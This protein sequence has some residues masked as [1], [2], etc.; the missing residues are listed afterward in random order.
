M[1]RFCMSKFGNRKWLVA[2]TTAVVAFGYISGANAAAPVPVPAAAK[3]AI[4]TPAPTAVSGTAFAIK[5]VIAIQDANGNTVT[6]NTSTVRVAITGGIGGTLLGNTIKNAVAGVATFDALGISGKVGTSYTLTY[7][8]G[9]LLA[10]TQTVSVTGREFKLAIVTPADGAVS[11]AVFTTQ[12]VV[13]IQDIQGNASV[14][15]SDSVTVAITGGAGATLMGT[16]SVTAVAGVAA[17]SGLGITGLPGVSYT[18]TYSEG[19]LVLARQAIT[20][21]EAV[22]VPA[23]VT[24]V[25][26]SKTPSSASANAAGK[27]T[28]KAQGNKA[29]NKAQ[30]NKGTKKK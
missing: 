23:V 21:A 24:P 5:P 19:T 28:N 18:L 14:A 10:A 30:G 16:T 2:A 15:G 29:T 26:N 8:D 25:V 6:T 12:P 7:T 1:G 13:T 11:G 20:L 3:L 22:D 9:S 27:A 17:F 4:T